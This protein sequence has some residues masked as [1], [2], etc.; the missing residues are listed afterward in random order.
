MDWI[1]E[2]Q[3][4]DKYGAVLKGIRNLRLPHGESYFLRRTATAVWSANVLDA[5]AIGNNRSFVVQ[6][7]C[8]QIL[9]PGR[10][11]FL[12]CRLIFVGPQDGSRFVSFSETGPGFLENL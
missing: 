5:I 12:R 6:W 9:A 1:H 10:L 11:T 2:D 8:A 7:K 3:D 4:R